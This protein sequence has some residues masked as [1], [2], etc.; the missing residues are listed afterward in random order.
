MQTTLRTVSISQIKPKSRS[1]SSEKRYGY[2]EIARLG[3]ITNFTTKKNQAFNFQKVGPVDTKTQYG[4]VTRSVS[5][6]TNSDYVIGERCLE[7]VHQAGRKN[8]RSNLAV[9]PL[10][11]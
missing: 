2:C 4:Q 9:K 11:I 6:I 1:L 3:V 10:A 5:N 8:W 7:A